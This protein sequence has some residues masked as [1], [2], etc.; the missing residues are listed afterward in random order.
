MSKVREKTENSI[1]QLAAL[2]PE[3]E[4]WLDSSPLILNDW[5]KNFLKTVP[6]TAKREYWQ[7]E[8]TALYNESAP[9]DSL[10]RGITT[11]P[12]L[13]LEVLRAQPEAYAQRIAEIK[14]LKHILSPRERSFLLYGDVI[15]AGAKMFLPVFER[16]GQSRG[17][18]SGQVDPRDYTDLKAMIRMGLQIK[19]LAPNLMIKMPGTKEGIQGIEILTSLGVATNATL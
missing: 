18:L 14:K 2:N 13:S 3:T 6:D 15:T 1:R 8:L 5:K 4:V 19:A 16:S 11:N 12:P 17:Y 7:E 9:A 10:L